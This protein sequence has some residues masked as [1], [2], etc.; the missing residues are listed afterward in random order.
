MRCESISSHML[1]EFSQSSSLTLSIAHNIVALT[2][3][4]TIVSCIVCAPHC[5]NK[6]RVEIN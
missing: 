2:V 3:G 5:E 1:E 6:G 4:C